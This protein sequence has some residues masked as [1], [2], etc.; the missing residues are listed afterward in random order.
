MSV[1]IS[2][3]EL[4]EDIW[5]LK[6][7]LFW[8]FNAM[9]RK[10]VSD[11]SSL[12]F[13]LDMT[14]ATNGVALDALYRENPKLAIRLRDAFMGVAIDIASGKCHLPDPYDESSDAGRKACAS[15]FANLVD[16]LERWTPESTDI[17]QE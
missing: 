16:I 12:L 2:T 11:D 4:P 13:Q 3:S 9:V 5:M 6:N 15:L 14:E 17:E 8:E 10:R 7:V 1:L